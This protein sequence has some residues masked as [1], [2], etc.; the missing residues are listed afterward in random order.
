MGWAVD[1]TGLYDLQHLAWPPTSRGC[2]CTSPRTARCSTTTPTLP[3]RSTT[4][5]GSPTCAATWPPSTWATIAVDGADVR[6]YFLW[7]LLDNF[8]WA[9]GYSKRF[10]A[11]Y[12]DYPTGTRI[13]KASAR[14]YA[15]VAR[16]GVLPG[17]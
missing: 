14:W 17:A 7:S 5:R 1:P 6:G 13:P 2:R 3:A 9:H 15:E 10:G 12:V 8:E 4:P 11:V 16:S